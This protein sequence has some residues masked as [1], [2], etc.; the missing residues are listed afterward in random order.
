MLA[1]KGLTILLCTYI[2]SLKKSNH[3]AAAAAF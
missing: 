3:D 1:I 2:H